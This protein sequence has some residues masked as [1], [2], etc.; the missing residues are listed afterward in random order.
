MASPART[1]REAPWSLQGPLMWQAPAFC[2]LAL[3]MGTG[4]RAVS[5]VGGGKG[6]PQGRPDHQLR[7]DRGNGQ[8]GP[9][10]PHPVGLQVSRPR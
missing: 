7:K 8:Q 2:F 5:G 6:S 9:R 4:N 3:G 10:G 1:R